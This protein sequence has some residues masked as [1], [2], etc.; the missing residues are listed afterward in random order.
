MAFVQHFHITNTNMFIFLKN[1]K[2]T[3]NVHG[4]SLFLKK[5][6]L[7][8][9]KLTKSIQHDNVD[10]QMPSTCTCFTQTRPNYK[11]TNTASM[12]LTNTCTLS[13]SVQFC[14]NVCKYTL[15]ILHGKTKSACKRSLANNQAH[16]KQ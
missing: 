11:Q 9:E 13:K 2:Q 4:V 5:K 14:L 8:L 16:P 10:K 12:R 15:N 1:H 6:I 3:Y 7:S